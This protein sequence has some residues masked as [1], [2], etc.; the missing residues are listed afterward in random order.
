M[1]QERLRLEFDRHR[2]YSDLVWGALKQWD[3]LWY[4]VA[5]LATGISIWYTDTVLSHTEITSMEGR[6]SPTVTCLILWRHNVDYQPGLDLTP[7][8]QRTVLLCFDVMKKRKQKYLRVCHQI[9]WRHHILNIK[10]Y[11][12]KLFSEWIMKIIWSK[13]KFLGIYLHNSNVSRSLLFFKKKT[14]YLDI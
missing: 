1:S 8:Y 13:E 11:I 14:I 2:R 4:W 9:T 10:I 5:E 6:S 3:E 7:V 12:G